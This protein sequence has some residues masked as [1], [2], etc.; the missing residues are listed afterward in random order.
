MPPTASTEARRGALPLTARMHSFCNCPLPSKLPHLQIPLGIGSGSS[1]YRE[2]T[3]VQAPLLRSCAWV[4]AQAVTAEAAGLGSCNVFAGHVAVQ[5]VIK[6]KCSSVGYTVAQHGAALEPRY[7]RLQ[8]R[9][10]SIV[11]GQLPASR[12]QKFAALLLH[13][14]PASSQPVKMS[15]I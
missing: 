10:A 1:S 13:L 7:T 3:H 11:D 12:E 9:Q 6:Q 4:V 2:G 5:A 8:S 15:L 14:R